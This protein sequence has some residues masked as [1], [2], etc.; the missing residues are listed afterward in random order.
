MEPEDLREPAT[1]TDVARSLRAI[2]DFGEPLPTSF[3]SFRVVET[4]AE[5]ARERG[6]EV[7][8]AYEEAHARAAGRSRRRCPVPST[9]RCRATT[10]S[11]RRTSSAARSS[12]GSS[13]GST[14]GWATATS[15]SPTSRSTTSS[16]RPASSACSRPTSPRRRPCSRVATL[17]LM[18]LMSDFRE[19]M[20]GRGADGALRPRLR[21]PGLRAEAL[22]PPAGTAADPD[23]EDLARGGREPALSCRTGALRDHRRRGRRHSIAYHLAELG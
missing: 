16:A 2:H 13:T 5:T 12:C 11:W 14:R 23:F 18:K 4:Y 3:D 19:A 8:A 1:L 17:R 22:R 6:A 20:W 9:S 10:T 21:L 7:P 15:T